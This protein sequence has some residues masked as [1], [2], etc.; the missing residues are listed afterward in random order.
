MSLLLDLEEVRAL[1]RGQV[2][3]RPLPW[4]I[5]ANPTDRRPPTSRHNFKC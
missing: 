2:F 5:V 1:V 4:I 3:A